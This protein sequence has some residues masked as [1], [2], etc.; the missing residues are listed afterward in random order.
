MPEHQVPVLPRSHWQQQAQA[1]I[2]GSKPG[3]N[4]WQLHLQAISYGPKP[5]AADCKGRTFF[6][7]IHNQGPCQ[8]PFQRGKAAKMKVK[9]GVLSAERVT[10]GADLNSPPCPS[11]SQFAIYCMALP[12]K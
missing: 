11:Y 8:D 2:A 9:I 10:R 5:V 1:S 6:W 12:C 4:R 3:P 7:K